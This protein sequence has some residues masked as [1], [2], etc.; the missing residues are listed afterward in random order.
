MPNF[1]EFF[2]GG[3]MARAGLG[4]GWTCLFANDFDHKK[5]LAYQANWGKGGELK[6]G[7]V[8]QVTVDALS[9]Y[10]DLIWGSFPCQDL[11]L[12]GGGAGLK[13]ERSGTFYPFWDVITGLIDDNRAPKII[14]IENVCGTLTSHGGR[15]F[16]AI[17]KTFGEAGYRYGAL[18]IN[19]SL[20]VPQSRP[21]LFVIGVRDDVTI[22][23]S[24]LS[25][26]PIEPFHTLGLRRAVDGIS[27]RAK[28]K[29]VWWNLPTPPRRKISFADIIEENPSS[30]DWHTAAETKQILAMMSP[31]NKAKVEA[32]KRSGRRMVGGVYKRT[33][34]DENGVKVQRAEIRFDDILGCLRTPAGGSSRQTIV[35]VDGNKIR[36]RL[37]SS[38]ETARL[39]G[40]DDAYKLPKNYNE[41]YHLT[42]DGVAVD[43]VRH[44]ARY[45]LEPLLDVCAQAERAA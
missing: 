22:D 12:A 33:R 43:V 19:A 26:E 41:A 27:S 40:L 20:F 21:R 35:V 6:V 1:Y 30:V 31:V 2:A 24:L 4:S 23:P 36:S 17:C 38:R 9:G 5:G 11:S 7:D 3:G 45:L 37:I 13:G 8:R 44:L 34:L 14:A 25:P 32:A 16:E 39:M 29:V 15:D 10:A 28:K 42:G 18:I